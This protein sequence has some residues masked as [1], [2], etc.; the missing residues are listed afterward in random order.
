MLAGCIQNLLLNVEDKGLTVVGEQLNLFFSRF[1]RAEQAVIFV[2][3]AAVNRF[4][5]N[6]VKTEDNFSSG[7][8]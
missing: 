7:S 8:L 1:I 6:I 5:K 2:I 4:G 3:A